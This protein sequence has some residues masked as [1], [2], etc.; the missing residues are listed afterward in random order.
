MPSLHNPNLKGVG[1]VKP[2]INEELSRGDQAEPS[3]SRYRLRV[4]HPGSIRCDFQGTTEPAV[5]LRPSTVKPDQSRQEAVP[6]ARAHGSTR[7]EREP[8]PDVLGL[9]PPRSRPSAPTLPPCGAATRGAPT[10]LSLRLHADVLAQLLHSPVPDGLLV[11]RQPLSE[12]DLGRLHGGGP[13]G[14]WS[15][16]GRSPPPLSLPPLSNDRRCAA[17]PRPRL[18]RRRRHAALGRRAE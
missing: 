16:P 1:L 6:T 2:R 15:I 3:D 12:L 11:G 17:P 13:R 7:R 14:R 10:C 18:R 9:C 5:G 8:V 4:R